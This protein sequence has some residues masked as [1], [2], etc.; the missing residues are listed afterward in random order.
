LNRLNENGDNYFELSAI[1]GEIS[2]SD[3]PVERWTGSNVSAWGGPENAE[4]VGTP[5][6]S[7]CRS[8]EA[9]LSAVPVRRRISENATSPDR[10]SQIV[11][12][13]IRF[14]DLSSDGF[15][16]CPIFRGF[17]LATTVR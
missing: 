5:R 11:P 10:S 9:L 17:T 8:R 14:S 2:V 3:I 16:P 15:L 7:K 6:P 13:S 1:D 4:R 12:P